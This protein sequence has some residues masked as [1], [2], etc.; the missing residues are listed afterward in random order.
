MQ[1][2]IDFEGWRKWRGF[3][4]EAQSSSPTDGGLTSPLQTGANGVSSRTSTSSSGAVNATARELDPGPG[5][6][7]RK[8]TVPELIKPVDI[9]LEEPPGSGSGEGNETLDSPASPLTSLHVGDP[10][11]PSGDEEHQALD[12][13]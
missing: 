7:K 10:I 6:G 8:S 13:T 5:A 1:A 11:E 12:V 4:D 9:L 2:L 3:A